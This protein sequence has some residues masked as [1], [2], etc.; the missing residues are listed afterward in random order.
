M[1][2]QVAHVKVLPIYSLVQI[3]ILGITI[4]FGFRDVTMSWIRKSLAFV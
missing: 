1:L 4:L 3:A 2:A